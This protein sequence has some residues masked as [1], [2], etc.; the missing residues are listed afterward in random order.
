MSWPGPAASWVFAVTNN[1]QAGA[2]LQDVVE[3]ALFRKLGVTNRQQYA[4]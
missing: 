2:Y 1:V 3:A 4:A